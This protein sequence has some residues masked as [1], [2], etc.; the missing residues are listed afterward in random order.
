MLCSPSQSCWCW[1]S[2]S[3][4]STNSMPA[5][6]CSHREPGLTILHLQT[7]LAGLD[8]PSRALVSRLLCDMHM[9]ANPRI[10]LTLRPQDAIPEWID[11]IVETERRPRQELKYVGARS[12]WQRP[13]AVAPESSS[14]RSTKPR[15]KR[16]LQE[17]PKIIQLDGANVSYGERR[18]LRDVTWHIQAGE[19]IVLSGANG[20]C[21]RST[22]HQ[23]FSP[24]GTRIPR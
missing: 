20:E 15:R 24:D 3:V 2:R 5:G 10:L 21:Q 11:G 22:G 6:E 1:K 17:A 14:T 13:S 18:V 12:A 23:M 7:N 9:Q 16:P 4:G 8:A 19:R